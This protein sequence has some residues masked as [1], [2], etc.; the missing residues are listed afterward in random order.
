MRPGTFRPRWNGPCE[1]FAKRFV[2]A[3][4]WRVQALLDK[5]EAIQECAVIFARCCRL[6]EGKVDNPAWF[7]S[8]FTR[9]LSRD[10]HTLSN[11]NAKAVAA[12]QAAKRNR[13]PIIAE[14]QDGPVYTALCHASEDLRQVFIVLA[15]APQ[16]LLGLM[17][18]YPVK[19]EGAW[20]RSMCRL[21]RTENVRSDLISEL[22]LL[23]E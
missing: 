20:S 19:D 2:A 3:N 4:L 12:R 10:F 21:A 11:K 9:A 7:M 23:L 13:H 8:L 15:A 22:R 5:D 6:Y 18:G 1:A 14:L 17:L 16:E